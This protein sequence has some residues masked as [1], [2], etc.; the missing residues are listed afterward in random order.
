MWGHLKTRRADA[1]Y[2]HYK[3]H[4]KTH[5]AYNFSDIP[6]HLKIALQLCRIFR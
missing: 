4:T 1:P 3:A 6:I 2:H 5:V